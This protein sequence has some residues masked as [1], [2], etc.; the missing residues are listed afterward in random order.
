VRHLRE[1][2]GMVAKELTVMAGAR[3]GVAPGNDGSD[4]T[5]EGPDRDIQA[6]RPA[7]RTGRAA[8]R[9]AGPPAADEE[10]VKICALPGRIGSGACHPYP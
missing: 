3:A 7:G 8:R 6:R 9:G 1:R 10:S 2:E 4:A 5:P